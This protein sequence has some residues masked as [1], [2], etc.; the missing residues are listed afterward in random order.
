LSSRLC[1]NWIWNFFGSVVKEKKLC[2]KKDFL[3]EFSLTV[4]FH[5]FHYESFRLAC[6]SNEWQAIKNIVIGIFH[7]ITFLYILKLKATYENVYQKSNWNLNIMI[8][9][10]L[11]AIVLSKLIHLVFLTTFWN[12]W[13][14]CKLLWTL[15]T[16]FLCRGNFVS[17]PPYLFLPW[18][19]AWLQTYSNL[20]TTKSIFYASSQRM[21]IQ[22]W[23]WP[24]VHGG[25]SKFQRM[26]PWSVRL[27][28]TKI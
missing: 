24:Q 7:V 1:C 12:N 18:L 23:S 20:V 17:S 6:S 13:W 4:L 27:N 28:V 9:L 3:L 8:F 19:V 14:F 26:Y 10:L 16:L 22:K 25:W 21:L 11:V 5:H 15:L 2:P